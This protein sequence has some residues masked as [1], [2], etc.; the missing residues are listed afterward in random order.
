MASRF[1]ASRCEYLKQLSHFIIQ[2]FLGGHA[3][4]QQIKAIFSDDSV[5]TGG[6]E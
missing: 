2:Y 6:D 4:E 3:Y 5:Q 1:K